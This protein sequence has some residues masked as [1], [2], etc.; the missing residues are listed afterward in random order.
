MN[1]NFFV[2][3]LVLAII[4]AAFYFGVY[5][6]EQTVKEQAINAG[7]AK[8]VLVTNSQDKTEFMFIK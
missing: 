5:L 6:G 3:W 8:Y 4:V 1:D 7:V 2:S